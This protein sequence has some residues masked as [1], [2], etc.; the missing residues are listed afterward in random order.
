MNNVNI[1]GNLTKDVFTNEYEKNGER[2]LV[3]NGSLAVNE[4]FGENTVVTYINF[5]AFNGKAKV[6]KDFTTKGSK[7]AITGRLRQN[8]YEKDGDT[9]YKTYVLIDNLELLETKETTEQR[10]KQNSEEPQNEKQNNQPQPNF[11]DEDGIPF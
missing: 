6:L 1:I 11:V 10:K 2:K 4:T 5:T 8:K 7:I 9:K 3:A